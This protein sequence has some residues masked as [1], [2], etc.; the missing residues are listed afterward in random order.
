MTNEKRRSRKRTEVLELNP[1]SVNELQAVHHDKYLAISA[2]ISES[3]SSSSSI[4]K[5]Y[6]ILRISCG[7]NVNS[8]GRC[9]PEGS[10]T[11][12]RSISLGPQL[13]LEFT[14]D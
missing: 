4:E 14:S 3:T 5:K 6:F 7:Y 10:Q 1:N 2:A 9:L 8:C 12:T 11:F 13:A